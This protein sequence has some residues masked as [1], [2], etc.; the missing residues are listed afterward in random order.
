MKGKS[1][2]K[3]MVS[4]LL[5]SALMANQLPAY[6]SPGRI[7]A[8]GEE[9]VSSELS[10][11]EWVMD[12]DTSQESP[13]TG[14]ADSV[15]PA[16]TGGKAA[17]AEEESA[18]ENPDPDIPQMTGE[19]ADSSQMAGG[20]T[21]GTPA[22]VSEEEAPQGS[23]AEENTYETSGTAEPEKPAG[24]EEQADPE[25]AETPEY[26]E[27]PELGEKSGE[28]STSSGTGSNEM[29][30][31][32]QEAMLPE[33]KISSN[34]EIVQPMEESAAGADSGSG[35][36]S[37]NASGSGPISGSDSEE[38]MAE[39][40]SRE[41][42]ISGLEETETE[43]I[44]DILA[45]Q[46]DAGSGRTEDGLW[47]RTVMPGEE[48]DRL[49]L[50]EEGFFCS[51][52]RKDGG[53][54]SEGDLLTVW[55]GNEEERTALRETW[56]NALSGEEYAPFYRLVRQWEDV[57]AYRIRVTDR[58]GLALQEDY[59]ILFRISDGNL[60]E[61]IRGG[62]AFLAGHHDAQGTIIENITD[63]MAF[64]GESLNFPPI[65]PG[66][67]YFVTSGPV[68]SEE[69]TESLT[70]KPVEDTEEL[71]V[72]ASGIEATETPDAKATEVLDT[73][74]TETPDE[75]ETEALD[76][77]ET[78]A[79]DAEETETLDAEETEALDTEE[80]ENL[81]EEK[82]EAV[83]HQVSA[84]SS[85]FRLVFEEGRDL[86]A[87]GELVRATVVPAEGYTLGDVRAREAV[88]GKE[89]ELLSSEDSQAQESRAA[90]DAVSAGEEDP[91]LQHARE[92][93]D[94]LPAGAEGLILEEVQ[95]SQETSNALSA[96]AD[97]EILQ[98][99]Q[100]SQETSNAL[101]A[102]ADEE[103]LQEMQ[104]T[105]EN[106]DAV[107]AGEEEPGPQELQ[108][109]QEA[110]EDSY[111][112][113][114]G[115]EELMLQE[116]QPAYVMEAASDGKP[117]VYLED[118]LKTDP[119]VAF[120]MPE[121]DTV[122]SADVL[123]AADADVKTVSLKNWGMDYLKEIP[124]SILEV[125]KEIHQHYYL[126]TK[127]V[128]DDG[129]VLGSD[130][131]IDNT[132]IAYC[133][134]DCLEDPDGNNYKEGEGALS[135]AVLKDNANIAKGLFYLY[136][137]PAWGKDVE[138]TDGKTYNIKTMMSTLCK[139]ADHYYTMSHYIMCYLYDSREINWNCHYDYTGGTGRHVGRFTEEGKEFI[140]NIG[141]TIKL[142]PSAVVKLSKSKVTSVYDAAT[143]NSVSR[144]V[145][146][147]SYEGNTAKVSL[148]SGVTL[149][150][151]TTGKSQTGSAKLSDGDVF[152]L[153]RKVS[154]DETQ[155]FTFKPLKGT[156]F[157]A[158]RLDS[159]GAYQNV[160][161]SYFD[162][163]VLTL[164]VV[165]ENRS[166]GY[167]FLRKTSADASATDANSSYSLKGA[168]F[169]LTG[170]SGNAEGETYT[171]TTDENGITKTIQLETGTYTVTET[172]APKGF[173]I[174]SK[175]A[176]VTVT[177]KHTK[178]SPAEISVKDTPVTSSVFVRKESAES[179]ITDQNS[180]YS[181]QGAVFE[182]TSTDGGRKYTLTTDAKG[183]TGTISVPMGTYHVKE[184]SAPKGY[185]IN[186][187]IPDI[188]LTASHTAEKPLEITV[189]DV[190]MTGVFDLEMIKAA[191][192]AGTR[193][194]AG[195][196]FEIRYYAS[197]S[198][199]GSPA[200]TFTYTT[201]VRNGVN[202]GSSR[203]DTGSAPDSGTLYKMGG[204]NVFPL[205]T[206]V[207]K[208]TKAP[209]GYHLNEKTYT[210]SI[211]QNGNQAETVY[212]GFDANSHTVAGK[213]VTIINLPNYG[214]IR[215]RK[216]DSSTGFSAQGDAVWQGAMFEVVSQN[217][218]LVTTRSAPGKAF[219]NGEV[220]T[221]I[222]IGADGTGT[223][224]D[225][226]QSGTYLV[227]EKT[228][229][230]GYRA[231]SQTFTVTI[232]EQ[233]GVI[234]D[235]TGEKD[236]DRH[237]KETVIRGGFH[238]EK[239]S[240]EVLFGRCL[241]GGNGQY[242]ADHVYG[243]NGVSGDAVLSGAAFEL[244]N[245]S[246]LPVMVD[247][248]KYAA[249][250]KIASFTTNEDGVIETAKDYLPYGSYEVV[251][252]TPPEGFTDRGVNLRI[253][254]QIRKEGEIVDLKKE[255]TV[256]GVTKAAYAANEEIRF[257]VELMKVTTPPSEEYQES[258]DLSDAV[259]GVAGVTFEFWL[260]SLESDT[261]Y[262][263]ITTDENGYASTADPAY[264]HG[265][266]PYGIYRVHE[267][268]DSLPEGLAPVKDFLVDGTGSGNVYDGKVYKGIF[269]NDAPLEEFLRIVKTD[270]ETG[271]AIPAAGA[272]FEIYK[273]HPK[274][275]GGKLVELND[276]SVHR[277]VSRFITDE[278]GGVYLP[279]R[280]SYGT[281]YIHEVKAPEGYFWHEDLELKVTERNSW[282]QVIE[283]H[284]ADEP[285]R[286]VIEIQ[287]TD[288][289]NGEPVD[290]AVFGIYAA[291]DI[292]TGDG[293]VR[294]AKDE[295]AGEL[296]TGSAGSG[297]GQSEPLY[298]GKYY[299]LELSA[300]DGY[301]C[302]P[303]E[304]LEFELIYDP[305]V[306]SEE[307]EEAEEDADWE[308]L[309]RDGGYLVSDSGEMTNAPTR[310]ILQKRAQS[311]SAEAV[312]ADL[313]E[314]PMDET[315]GQETA[316]MEASDPKTPGAE[317]N[318]AETTDAEGNDVETPG[319]EANDAE[320]TD[321]ER[322]D[323]ETAGE[324]ANG[325]ETADLEGSGVETTARGTT[326]TIE[327]KVLAGIH[328]RVERIKEAEEVRPVT[329]EVCTGGDYVTDENGMISL[330][331]IGSGVYRIT[332]TETLPGFVPDPE[333]RYFLVDALGQICLSDEE[334]NPS[335]EE[336][337]DTLT[338]DWT[339]EYT[340]WDF[341]KADM[342]GSEIDG[343]SMQIFDDQGNVTAS[344]IS[345]GEPHR[346]NALPEGDYV[347]HEE[348]PCKGYVAATDIPFTVTATG[349]LCHVTMTDK[350]LRVRKTD[351]T[352]SEIPGALLAVYE[353]HSHEGETYISQEP[354]DE[355]I[356][357]R[358]PH[359]V[360]G[361]RAGASYRLVE[362]IAARGY[363]MAQSCDFTVTDDGIDQTV[364]L[365][366]KQ[367]LVLKTDTGIRALAGAEFEV[368]QVDDERL[369][370]K[371]ISD[372]TAHAVSGLEI[373]RSYV[374]Y[375]TK[376]P[377]GYVKA[378]PVEFTVG[379]DNS[380]NDDPISIADKRVLV[381]KKDAA[382]GGEIPGARL[383]VTD[384][385]TKE[386][387]DEW[388]SGTEPHPVSGL[389]VGRSYILTEVLAP[390]GYATAESI[391][392]TVTDDGMDQTVIMKD[393]PIRI[394]IS[395]SDITNG[396]PVSGA[397]LEIRDSSG[398]IVEKWTTNRK[399][400]EIDR[401]APGE[402]TLTEIT[403]PKGYQVAETV[404]FT[405]KDDSE[406]QM[407]EMKDAP[408][409][410]KTKETEEK[411]DRAET[412]PKETE[413][414]KEES[415][416]KTQK[417]TEKKQTEKST[418]QKETEP[419]RE[420]TTVVSG[421]NGGG[422]GSGTNASGIT[423]GN[424]TAASPG[425]GDPAPLAALL[426]LMLLALT[427][428][429]WSGLRILRQKRKCH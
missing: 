405:V 259:R 134:Q 200:R 46:S 186:S 264:P 424:R 36:D 294:L 130:S 29:D 301:A 382:G 394:R 56:L 169:T 257:D 244:Y 218:Y 103:I 121:E 21:D 263:S 406:I 292:V 216:T 400:H 95:D 262:L 19:P 335:G 13:G 217:A 314:K 391:Q 166:E 261:P 64:D 49:I 137:G 310:L 265:R 7:T 220:I 305:A 10:T 285:A 76:V 75:K 155:T 397:V 233:N 79:L 102:G 349:V 195:A 77:E 412:K 283:Y 98:E 60:A 12:M 339:N 173:Q 198:A 347:L 289:T 351:V 5:A 22:T 219:G 322:N 321:A 277:K 381:Y 428:G 364:V 163:G 355:W 359:D 361:L 162:T 28:N 278:E 413:K 89:V 150:N 332:E 286:G 295:K 136:G 281:Y 316:D 172:K 61:E 125:D 399:P 307:M 312:E 113:P 66:D 416:K 86:Y 417:E 225:E 252:K 131:D 260:L 334:G 389:V 107:S 331:Y 323:V 161:A 238:L 320:T 35:N 111:A 53:L 45:Q 94:S 242:P 284:F 369:I 246:A 191:E 51:V 158:V 178:A 132:V 287:K 58:E 85:S 329:G 267:A 276:T 90:S 37:G 408:E 1:L 367:Q 160:A 348:A 118:G 390:E 299:T 189:R 224:A 392:F 33:A 402:Y 65:I 373:G 395:K 293:T 71:A 97:E 124:Q 308:T 371:W 420:K 223:T 273:N 404:H 341:S 145:E 106:S 157:I 414:E 68:H 39:N 15:E 47:F 38:E 290:G 362:K 147:I 247:G 17:S 245:R 114:A 146:Y 128:L 206:Y 410:R 52:T 306:G 99:V 357:T 346:I 221:T 253:P 110:R 63:R 235:L 171:L 343:A 240:L 384:A 222:T 274:K 356:S 34:P 418:P 328:F 78:E 419:A 210:V 116:T 84:E 156:D 324:E 248:Q 309:I 193:S 377:A 226:I 360:S 112:L 44:P 375:E 96:G 201:K 109:T 117:V 183:V 74:E 8:F 92:D 18:G 196:V 176:N 9:A 318:D 342:N 199:A 23:S 140:R 269:K 82:T 236:A 70:E 272:V 135:F 67:W 370:D 123:L 54:F 345:G 319:A 326:E 279:Q 26:S 336:R 239:Q 184:I 120:I 241:D 228:P 72:S 232:P 88:S 181:L 358:T 353:L 251:E 407:V 302:N 11:E 398:R 425:T 50:E 229:P 41:D 119:E 126:S 152:H 249:G 148:P 268:E 230:A 104:E 202:D 207:L 352:G 214:K 25:Y 271:K 256:Q 387:T 258:G 365:V 174:N 149:V 231:V 344:W 403:A 388:I 48:T 14:S 194:T 57:Y 31:S 374:L 298:L 139:N 291:E 83:F 164:T 129:T 59:E 81:T 270:E 280:L 325:A 366:D 396:K 311:E 415:G 411:P 354:V 401:L 429:T 368:R 179:G 237:V 204:K 243:D 383:T 180:L 159:G 340:R 379:S 188:T 304:R 115:E 426:L 208:E 187:N 197:G 101:S 282:E 255:T 378:K 167:A 3:R 303:E 327:G 4:I 209:A 297:T 142:L 100:D 409:E 422:S 80:T 168:K 315:T 190:P 165:W 133:V 93:S 333:P 105:G 427:A 338:L 91:M 6:I 32:A 73:E 182:L 337:S 288:R 372:G 138:G 385:Q 143:G 393:A 127:I 266:L 42:E 2:S 203:I 43:E 254:F 40:N 380:R 205:G 144:S 87:E 69:E 16:G 211:R 363:V 185:L 215:I 300:P 55:K 192:N 122:I 275:D 250:T 421:G 30:N 234:C 296:V 376:A 154:S 153:E 212:S 151:E 330:S 386:Q 177:E 317:A 62:N 108:E 170:I 20:Q 175:I 141:D 213:S 227:R 423:G 313:S 350:I 24:P 27:T